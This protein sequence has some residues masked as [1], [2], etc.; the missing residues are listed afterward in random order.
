MS[1]DRDCSDSHHPEILRKAYKYVYDNEEE[2]KK[3]VSDIM[4]DK[5]AVYAWWEVPIILLELMLII[6]PAIAALPLFL[7][8]ATFKT[9]NETIAGAIWRRYDYLRRKACTK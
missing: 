3:T 7:L 5:Y 6:I 1:K 4:S 9:V 2:F 8:L